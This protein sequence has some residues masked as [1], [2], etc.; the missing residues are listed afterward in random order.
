MKKL[1]FT[2]D[3]EFIQHLINRDPVLKKLIHKIGTIDITLQQNYYQ[4]IVQQ[5]I[6]Q[7]LSL[8]AAATIIGRVE[9][10]WKKFDPA[11]INELEDDVLRSA[12]VSKPKITY[13]RDLTEKHLTQEVDLS[14]LHLHSDEEVLQQL[15]SVKGIGKW[16]AEMFLIFSLGRLNVLSYGDVSIQNAIRWLYQLDKNTPLDLDIYR[17]R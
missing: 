5:I 15:T 14:Q 12:G 16:T 17:E 10:Q 9:K 13:I 3:H 6:G 11:I 2:I 1:Y 7:Q 4:S 8:K